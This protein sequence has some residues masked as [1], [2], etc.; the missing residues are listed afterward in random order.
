MNVLVM[1]RDL[2]TDELAA[3]RRLY[4]GK[5]IYAIRID[6]E[7]SEQHLQLCR[8]KKADL[9]FLPQEQPLPVPAMQAGFKHLHLMDGKL[10][11]LIRVV[12]EFKEHRPFG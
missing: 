9:V 5:E 3:L 11:E 2:T 6:P 12:P 4:P 10:L 7:T 1:R 8:D